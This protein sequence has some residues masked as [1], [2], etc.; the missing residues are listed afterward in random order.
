MMQKVCAHCLIMQYICVDLIMQYT[1]LCNV[2][3]PLYDAIN[4]CPLPYFAFD[5]FLHSF[6]QLTNQPTG[7][8]HARKSRGS[9][10]WLWWVLDILYKTLYTGCPKKKALS[11]LLDWVVLRNQVLGKIMNFHW[12][13]KQMASEAHYLPSNDSVQHIFAYI[14]YKI[15]I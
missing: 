3:C 11:E 9:A 1:L 14:I 2:F 6:V 15:D 8:S 5:A 12:G 7:L 10:S 13:F 4:L